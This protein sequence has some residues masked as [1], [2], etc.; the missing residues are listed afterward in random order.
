MREGNSLEKPLQVKFEKCVKM[1][2]MRE[3]AGKCGKMPDA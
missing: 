1:R 3:N 2:E